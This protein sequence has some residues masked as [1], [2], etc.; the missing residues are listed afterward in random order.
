MRR[1][2]G[3]PANRILE[4]AADEDAQLIV[5]GSKGRTGLKN[6]LIGSKSERVAKLSPVPVT[7]V[8]RAREE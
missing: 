8:K 4:V 1:T 3:L 7:I 6:L 5:M 2:S